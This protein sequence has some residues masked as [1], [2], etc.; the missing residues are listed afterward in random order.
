MCVRNGM[1]VE[2]KDNFQDQSSPAQD[3]FPYLYQDQEYIQK[4]PATL[5]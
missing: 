3:S 4:E 5:W 1:Y 2:A